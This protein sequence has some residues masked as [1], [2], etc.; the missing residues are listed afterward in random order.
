M[1]NV[2]NIKFLEYKKNLFK[3]LHNVHLQMYVC[4]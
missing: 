2:K 1:R 3:Y 4:S